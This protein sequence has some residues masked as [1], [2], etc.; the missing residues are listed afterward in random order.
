MPKQRRTVIK[1]YKFINKSKLSQKK[2]PEAAYQREPEKAAGVRIPKG[3]R[4]FI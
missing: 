3:H 4:T 2:L 1:K